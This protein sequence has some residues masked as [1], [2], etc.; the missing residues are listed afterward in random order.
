MIISKHRPSN[1][2]GQMGYKAPG[3]IRKLDELD[4]ADLAISRIENEIQQVGRKR[5]YFT[6]CKEKP[7]VIQKEIGELN[8]QIEKLQARINTLQAKLD[9]AVIE[10]VLSGCG[11]RSASLDREL[12]EAR[13][14]REAI[15][16]AR[17]AAREAGKPKTVWA[18]SERVMRVDDDTKQKL[19]AGGVDVTKLMAVLAS[20]K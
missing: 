9:P 3:G 17:R 15:I 5:L 18:A 12:V 13:A 19:A 1:A 6:L 16:Q 14:K 2:R 20:M 8:E 7:E 11:D 4:H 10:A